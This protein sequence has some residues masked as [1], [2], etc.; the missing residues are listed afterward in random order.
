MIRTATEYPLVV[1]PAT[2]VLV[3]DVLGL[4]TWTI[5]SRADLDR[6][7]ARGPRGPLEPAVRA[8]SGIVPTSM[9]RRR[10]L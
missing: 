9:P 1:T 6:D 4:V 8:H 3:A 7:Q 10:A 2:A 5:L